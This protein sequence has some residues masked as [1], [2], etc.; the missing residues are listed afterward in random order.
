MNV[1]NEKDFSDRILHVK[2]VSDS[3]DSKSD[4]LE[5]DDDSDMDSKS[6]HSN[7]KQKIEGWLLFDTFK[8]WTFPSF[9][10]LIWFF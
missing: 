4:S 5:S 9:S 1:F 2:I 3:L 7:K 6:N 8:V 10:V